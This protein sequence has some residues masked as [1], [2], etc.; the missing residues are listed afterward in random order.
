[1][2]DS[3]QQ[4]QVGSPNAARF[5]CNLVLSDTATGNA[6]HHGR[7]FA[8]GLRAR[9]DVVENAFRSFGDFEFVNVPVGSAL[10]EIKR[11]NHAG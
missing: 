9:L 1:M 6:R 3:L 2:E 11:E 5:I 7:E 4:H 10:F 8:V